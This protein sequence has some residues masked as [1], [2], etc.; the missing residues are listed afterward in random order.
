MWDIL[1]QQDVFS[2]V[3]PFTMLESNRFTSRSQHSL[4]EDKASQG[5]GNERTVRLKAEEQWKRR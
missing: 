3:E 2:S 1:F 4:M 5:L